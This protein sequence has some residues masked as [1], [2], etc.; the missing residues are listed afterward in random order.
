MNPMPTDATRKLLADRRFPLGHPASHSYPFFLRAFGKRG[1]HTSGSLSEARLRSAVV[2]TQAMWRGQIL[3]SKQTGQGVARL[4]LRTQMQGLVAEPSPSIL[5]LTT[6][7]LVLAPGLWNSLRDQCLDQSYWCGQSH[8]P[9]FPAFLQV[10][11]PGRELLF[12]SG[13]CQCHEDKHSC[14]MLRALYTRD[15]KKVS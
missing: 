5:D 12:F 10:L 2:R 8:R 15:R 6:I 4:L 13:T 11:M 1:P 3:Y 9:H 7:T 14:F